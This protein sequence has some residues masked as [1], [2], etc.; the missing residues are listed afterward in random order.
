[1]R[2]LLAAAGRRTKFVVLAAFLVFALGTASQAGKFEDA[3]KNE[4]SSFLPGD[5]ESVA[6]L[7]KL[8][9]LPSGE[10]APAVVVYHRDGGLTATDRAAVER[11]RRAIAAARLRSV[12]PSAD[13]TFSADGASALVVVPVQSLGEATTFTDAIDGIRAATTD[14][15][16]GGLQ[17]KVT[18]PAGF[19]ADAVKVFGSINGTLLLAAGLLVL[20]LLIL[21]YRSP[22]FWAIPFVTVLLAEGSSRGCGYLL[23][24]AGVTIN[25]Q[26]GGIL[27]V[28]VFGAGTDYALLLVARYR[29]ELRRHEDKHDA[30]RAALQAAGPAIFA[31]GMTV[32]I[33]LLTLSLAKVNGTAGLGP[34]GAMGVALAMLSMLT[35]LP[36]LLVVCGRRAFWA[37]RLDTIP[38]YGAEGTDETHGAWRRIGERVARSPRRIWAG[39]AALLV[40][41]ALGNLGLDT[42]LTS[43]NQF[44]GTVESVQGQELLAK[45]FPAGLSAPTQVVVPPGA[46]PAKVSAALTAHRDLVDGVRV[47]ERS[48]KVG[49]VLN[50]ALGREPYSTAAYDDVPELR[51]IVRAA[52]GDGVLVGG[53]TAEEADLRKAAA[54]DNRV[55]LPIA[56]VVVFLILVGLL[57]SITAPLVLIGTVVLSFAAAFGVGVF[58]FD[59][60][61]GFPGVDPAMPLLTFVF[62]VALGID[63]NIFL[64]ARVREEA[65]KHGTRDGTLRGLAVTGGVITS[66]GIVLAGTFSALAVMP[67]VTLTEIGFIVAFGVLLD[68][69]LVR[70]VLVPALVFDV[71]RRVWW[72]SAL[73]RGD[74]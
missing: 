73:A 44:R 74:D 18:G 54:R 30:M 63:Y 62:L 61:F 22:I 70:S 51:R 38:R 16:G 52:G 29:E 28:L 13:P 27:P 59:H 37:P 58:V 17:V 71:G 49:T 60:V 56:L 6:A 8:K 65:Q 1:M 47:A 12:L 5:V 57:R 46:D 64:M 15:A 69:F 23:A 10:T 32:C 24:Q 3:Q 26:A 4:T 43:S 19:G 36:A 66:A 42:G 33:A 40:V 67:L 9:E 11:D 25:G 21:I 39:A 31:S 68:T 41:F 55:I 48:P 2:I 34:V 53:P 7:K 14:R 45:S 50:V 35:M 72:P 20:I